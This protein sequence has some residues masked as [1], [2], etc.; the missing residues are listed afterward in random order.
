MPA[1]PAQELPWGIERVNGGRSGNFKTAWVLDTGVDFYHPDLNVVVERS[2]SFVGE[3][4]WDENGH[5]THVAGTIA[6]IDNDIGVIGVAPGAP[7]VAVK[8]LDANGNGTLSGV[9]AGVDHV[10]R[11]GDAGDVANMSLAG[12]A[13]PTLDD[14]VTN[15]ASKGIRFVLAAG[16]DA[17]YAGNVSPARANGP[18][19]Y[20]VSAFAPGDKW[21]SFSN[22]GNPPVDFAEPGLGIYSTWIGGYYNSMSGTSMAAP[23][24]AGILLQ[25]NA[26]YGGSVINDPDGSS[27][28]IGVV[29]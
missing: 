16:N 8:V 15:A 2:I 22:Y 27:D 9:L 1:Q 24:L 21:V 3:G 17:Q 11:F 23:H 10:A 14:A 25:G 13:S 4:A 18:N 29:P 28:T 19:V 26:S 12:G 5:G 20:T 7:V 6:A